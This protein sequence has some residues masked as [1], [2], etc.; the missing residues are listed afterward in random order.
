MSADNGCYIGRFLN[1]LDNTKYEYRV[2]HAQNIEDCD[3]DDDTL[4]EITDAYRTMYYANE[5]VFDNLKDAEIEA[6]ELYSVIINDDY[7]PVCEY[8]ICHINYDVVLNL[9]IEEAG[10]KIDDYWDNIN[11]IKPVEKR[12]MKI[13]ELKYEYRALLSDAR[14]LVNK[15]YKS[16]IIACPE[17]TDMS[18]FIA[19]RICMNEECSNTIMDEKFHGELCEH[20]A[21]NDRQ[22]CP[23]CHKLKCECD[24]GIEI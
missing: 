8:G 16:R 2:I 1:P 17:L 3:Y 12:E 11:K 4:H 13:D 7:C 9:N 6:D 20:C 23:S 21:I 5:N 19:G 22:Y 24:K 10:K 14:D 15:L 18:V